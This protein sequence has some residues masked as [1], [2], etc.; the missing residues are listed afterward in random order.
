MTNEDLR[1]LEKLKDLKSEKIID[2]KSYEKGVKFYEW[3]KTE[4]VGSQISSTFISHVAILMQRCYEM[5]QFEEVN[6]INLMEGMPIDV[7]I[8][9]ESAKIMERIEKLTKRQITPAEKGYLDL[10]I[11]AFLYDNY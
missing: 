10:Y 11:K 6:D 4:Y 8:K 7:K 1:V 2:N 5:K 9:R 3:L